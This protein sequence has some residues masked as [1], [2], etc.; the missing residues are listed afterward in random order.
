MFSF[1]SHIASRK[2]I[3]LIHRETAK[4]AN[5]DPSKKIEVGDYGHI[6]RKTGEFEVEGN[7]YKHSSTAEKAALFPPNI[8]YPMLSYTVSSHVVARTGFE[9]TPQVGVQGIADAS[10]KGEWQFGG[11]R[12]ALLIMSHSRIESMPAELLEYI[13]SS[14]LNEKGSLFK[15][16]GLVTEIH[17]CPAYSL[18]M[19]AGNNEKL[20]LAF[21]VTTPIPSAPGATAGG[22]VGGEWWK[23]YDAGVYQ[24]A[25]HPE[26][27]HTFVPLFKLKKTPIRI[28]YRDSPPPGAM[29]DDEWIDSPVPWHPLDEEGQEFKD[30]V[31][32]RWQD[33]C[34]ELTS[35]YT[36]TRFR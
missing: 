3:D 13:T 2:Y 1:R 33:E 36:G 15:E 5:W 7:V 29:A 24:D 11:K 32:R 23:E 25:A 20:R 31:G 8:G 4:Y 28:R 17:T 14:P 30:D 19:S 27:K 16:K 9:V 18:Y 22:K 6:N 26:G 35:S 10:I 34:D 12:G 21:H